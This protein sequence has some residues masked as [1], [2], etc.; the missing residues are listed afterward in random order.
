MDHWSAFFFI[1]HKF[2]Y[3]CSSWHNRSIL[4]GFGTSTYSTKGLVRPHLWIIWLLARESNPV[5]SGTNHQ[6]TMLASC[7]SFGCSLEGLLIFKFLDA[8]L[9]FYP[10]MGPELKAYWLVPSPVAGLVSFLVSYMHT[11]Q[12][13]SQYMIFD[14]QR[15]IKGCTWKL[16]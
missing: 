15:S 14:L 5:C 13:I 6:G 4:F 9:P 3:G 1:W 8:I 16:C 7:S 11:T 2:Q 12:L 10:G